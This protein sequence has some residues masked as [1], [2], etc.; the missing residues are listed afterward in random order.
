ME[1]LDERIENETTVTAGEVSAQQPEEQVVEAAVTEQ[2]EEPVVEAVV[3]EQPEEQVVEAVVTEQPASVEV[4]EEKAPEP[5]VAT[6]VE[7]PVTKKP[8][9]KKKVLVIAGA[10]VAAI[11]VLVV[12]L[13]I[14]VFRPN[15]I[16][17]DACDALDK[18][19]F[20]ECQQLLDKIPNH[21]KA[22][23]LDRKLNLA[24]AKSYIGRQR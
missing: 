17:K 21:K 3:T 16:Y 7:T 11:A 13:I 23:A 10:A 1:Q 19:D 9:D 4:A 22:A 15:A 8:V 24:I 6:P 5:V 12:I 20:V 18:Q 14:T 2:P